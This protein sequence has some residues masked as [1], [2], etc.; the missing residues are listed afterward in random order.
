MRR[1]LFVL[2]AAVTCCAAVLTGCASPSVQPPAPP[3]AMVPVPVDGLDEPADP[4]AQA[5]PVPGDD[6]SSLPQPG[7]APVQPAAFTPADLNRRIAAAGAGVTSYDFQ[8]TLTD[9]VD[10][11]M[12]M[13]GS[14]VASPTGYDFGISV[15]YPGGAGYPGGTT[16]IRRVAGT[17]YANTGPMTDD[18]FLV[19]DA[20]DAESTGFTDL[21]A[22]LNL[23]D[24][25]TGVTAAI[26][27]VVAVGSPVLLDG[28]KAQQYDITFDCTKIPEEYADDLPEDG[29]PTMTYSY[30]MGPDDLPRQART[31]NGSASALLMFSHYGSGAPVVAP[32][33]DEITAGWSTSSGA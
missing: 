21:P 6:P 20:D 5:D 13:A 12:T 10:G 26:I 3:M 14:V 1:R 15:T 25:V 28:V 4:A 9:P 31:T 17:M 22:M 30:W 19:L 23:A 32:T 16:H 18:K 11:V 29:A 8:W 33:A 7:S 24:G 2:A 27:D